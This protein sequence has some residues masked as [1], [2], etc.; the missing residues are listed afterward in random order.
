MPLQLHSTPLTLPALDATAYSC[1]AGSYACA[2]SG[3]LNPPVDVVARSPVRISCGL[4]NAG[5]GGFHKL[6]ALADRRLLL[7]NVGAIDKWAKL[8]GNRGC[9]GP[10]S[11][12]ASYGTSLSLIDGARDDRGIP[13]GLPSGSGD[14]DAEGLST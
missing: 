11:F 3:L 2:Q 5:A 12:S 6:C 1:R 9:P 7:L 4:P 10:R 14:G 13:I 8:L